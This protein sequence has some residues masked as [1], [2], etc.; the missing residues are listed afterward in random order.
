MTRKVPG[1]S[2]YHLRL[3]GNG[4]DARAILLHERCRG[5]DAVQAVELLY[6]AG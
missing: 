4:P 5:H 2:E 3:A 1:P 6:G